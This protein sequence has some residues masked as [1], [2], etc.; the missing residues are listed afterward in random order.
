MTKPSRIF[1]S[2][3]NIC[4]Q[5]YFPTFHSENHQIAF[6]LLIADGHMQTTLNLFI[7]EPNEINSFECYRAF[8]L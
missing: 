7:K 8:L 5:D 6:G 2:W 1:A 4:E 3:G